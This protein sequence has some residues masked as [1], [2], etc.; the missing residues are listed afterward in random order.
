[1]TNQN[2]FDS[3]SGAWPLEGEG[4]GG[5]LLTYVDS[6]GGFFNGVH[7]PSNFLWAKAKFPKAW[8]IQISVVSPSFPGLA[9]Y[10]CERGALSVAEVCGLANTELVKSK[11]FPT[12]YGSA[13]TRAQIVELLAQ[14]YKQWELG[15]DIGYLL[16]DPDNDPTTIPPGN[17]GKQFFWGSE[18]DQSVVLP[19]WEALEP[20]TL[21]DQ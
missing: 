6:W 20:G 10:D 8:L 7:Y 17:V 1:M 11:K 5:I 2:V 13:D 12:L 9:V 19:T 3:A 14:D 18:Y 21:R 15:R 4:A 16:A